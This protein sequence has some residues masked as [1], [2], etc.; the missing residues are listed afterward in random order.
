[1]NTDLKKKPKKEENLKKR[2]KISKQKLKIKKMIKSQI[3]RKLNY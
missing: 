3:I 1:M 2:R